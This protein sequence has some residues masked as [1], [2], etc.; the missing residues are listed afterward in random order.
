MSVCLLLTGRK[1]SSLRDKSFLNIS[2]VPCI[3]II[4]KEIYKVGEIAHFFC[5]SD[6]PKILN[7][8]S[9]FGF[10]KIVRPSSLGSDNAQHIDVINHALKVIKDDFQISPTILVVVLANNPIIFKQWIKLSIDMINQDSS[11]TSVAPV[12]EYS[13]HSPFRSKEINQSGFLQSPLDLKAPSHLS[14]NRQSLPSTYFLCHNFWTL[15]TSNWGIDTIHT[16]DSPW[17][18]MGRKTKPI[19]VPKSHDI[20]TLDDI[21]ICEQILKW[22]SKDLG[23]VTGIKQ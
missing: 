11:I 14:T 12:Y 23:N 21:I 16:G 18:F 7:R 8:S 19:V 13:D 22:Y 6:C 2:N 20:H 4:L 10:N 5:S 17:T 3:D 15:N 1:G 9:E